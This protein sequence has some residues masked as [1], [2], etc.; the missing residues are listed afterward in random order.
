MWNTEK[1]KSLIAAIESPQAPLDPVI[2]DLTSVDSNIF[3]LMGGFTSKARQ[4]G[5]VKSSIDIVTEECMSG[6]YDHAVCT[7]LA[8]TTT[9]DDL[10]DEASEGYDDYNPEEY[11]FRDRDENGRDYQPV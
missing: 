2:F 10:D 7:L 4:Q 3:N 8:V 6:D 9:E 1:F 5:W 11:D